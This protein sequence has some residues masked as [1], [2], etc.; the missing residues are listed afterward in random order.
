LRDV[1]E[2]LVRWID[3]FKQ[4]GDIAVQYDPT[5]ASLPW[6]GVRL[7]LQVQDYCPFFDK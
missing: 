5:H 7:I 1:F 4:I 6:A 2:K 3:L